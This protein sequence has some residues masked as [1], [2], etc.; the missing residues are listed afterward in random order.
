[1]A[2]ANYDFGALNGALE[3]VNNTKVTMEEVV[4]SI[5]SINSKL[6]SRIIEHYNDYFGEVN[7]VKNTMS[8]DSAEM[9]IVY[10]WLN[11]QILGAKDTDVVTSD[12]ADNAQ[13]Y[14]GDGSVSNSF[15]SGI[16]AGT[17]S[18]VEPSSV[19]E[20]QD[21][22]VAPIK[23]L[24]T[25]KISAEVFAA[26]PAAVQAAVTAKLQEVGYTEAEIA[27]IKSGKMG[28]STV[29]LET[30][31]GKLET[32]Y[33]LHPEIRQAIIDEYGF[34]IFTD[35]GRVDKD[36]L[37]LLLLV[38]DKKKDDKYN[39]VKELREKYGI[40]IVNTKEL[41]DLSTKLKDELT[42]NQNIRQKIIDLYGFDIFNDDGTIDEDKLRVAML[43]DSLD[44]NDEYDIT[45][46]LTIATNEETGELK[47]EDVKPTDSNKEDENK[48]GEKKDDT[49]DSGNNSG[50]TNTSTN[51]S[52]SGGYSGGGGYYSGGSSG[53]SSSSP[54]NTSAEVKVDG[55]NVEDYT[56][57]GSG[58]AIVEILDNDL[59]SETGVDIE[60]GVDTPEEITPIDNI[61]NST[62]V[63]ESQAK[64]SNLGGVIAGVGLAGA[65]AT[66][67]VIGIMKN[68]KKDEEEDDD[69]F[70][71]Y[72]TNT[73]DYSDYSYEYETD[74]S[75]DNSSDF[76]EKYDDEI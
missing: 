76:E 47:P 48:N 39:I 37:A 46:F 62:N 41:E 51:N 22:V 15:A 55:L 29:L 49:I 40:D 57:P 18:V 10:D 36:R 61:D 19:V 72:P 50:T 60:T 17:A 73:T 65:A 71:D 26:L 6:D 31:K 13:I 28:V 56:E 30:V 69:E 59:D 16:A 64:K 54:S 68:K 23:P 74:S 4:D 32:T 8:S 1:M 45:K 25:Y 35:D 44:P 21:A 34:D 75:N 3:K 38:D 67:G 12:Q 27:D 43:M 9:K 14:N 58:A 53:G 66:A 7:E 11:S 63:D 42:K 70:G 24:D 33:L 2:T 5:T 52:N 20:K